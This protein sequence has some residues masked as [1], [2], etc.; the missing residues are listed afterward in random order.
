MCFELT[1]V[2]GEGWGH[3]PKKWGLEGWGFE[4]R[5]AQ[6]RK[7]GV[8]RVGV[9]RVGAQPRKSGAPK[10][11]RP[12]I[13]RFFLPVPQNSFFSS[14][15]GGL[16]VEF[17]WC[18]KRW[19]AHVK[20]RRP[21]SRRGA[22]LRV[23]VFTNTTKKPRENPQRDTKKSENGE[24]LQKTGGPAEGGPASQTHKH[25]QTQVELGLAKVG[26]AKLGLADTRR[27]EVVADGLPLTPPWCPLFDG[28]VPL[29]HG[30]PQWMG[31]LW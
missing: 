31:S 22:H 20:P 3:G 29:D 10:G 23:P 8:R 19:G 25:T 28:M 15:S 11:G 14:L 2:G 18:L 5:G 12:K 27:L 26:L 7:S 6:P 17:W 1:W 13:S 16:L 4:G 30:A 9:R 24:R 21:R